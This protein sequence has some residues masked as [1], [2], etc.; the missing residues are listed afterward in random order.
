M[1]PPSTTNVAPVM[2]DESLT[3]KFAKDRKGRE[4]NQESVAAAPLQ[5]FFAEG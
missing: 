5:D 4:E 3:A 1:S 2:N